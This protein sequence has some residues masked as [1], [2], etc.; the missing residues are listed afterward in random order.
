MKL[1]LVLLLLVFG[2]H[3][4]L[5]AQTSLSFTGSWKVAWQGEKR[6]EEATLVIAEDGGGTWRTATSSRTNNCVGKEVPISLKKTADNEATVKLKFSEVLPG[7]ADSTLKLKLL[8]EKSMSGTR[9]KFDLT[10][11]R[12]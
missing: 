2:I 7:C 4:S 3:A 5:S 6:L 8:D 9:G 12:E 1:R 11:V 10:A